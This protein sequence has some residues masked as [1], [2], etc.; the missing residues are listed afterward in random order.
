MNKKITKKQ[1]KKAFIDY[2]DNLTK[3]MIDEE[4]NAVIKALINS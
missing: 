3:D 1:A 2:A 4:K